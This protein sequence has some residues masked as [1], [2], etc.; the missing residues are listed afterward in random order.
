MA[1]G[2]ARIWRG[3]PL[4]ARPRTLGRVFLERCEA[5]P[6]APAVRFRSATGWRTLTYREYGREVRE[7]ALG[8]LALG[9]APGEAVLLASRTR[10]EWS[11]VDLAVLLCG[12]V[13]VPAFPTL[14]PKTVLHQ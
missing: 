11:L 3:G 12:A 10:Y 9:L 2:P 6:D 5:T 8:F 14:L 13:V 1:A 4:E 7:R